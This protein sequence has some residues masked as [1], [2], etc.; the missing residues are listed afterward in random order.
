MRVFI[1]GIAGFIGSSL[2]DR[3]LLEGYEVWGCDTFGHYHPDY[4][5]KLKWRNVYANL[6]NPKYKLIEGDFSEEEVTNILATTEFDYVIHL[7]AHAGVRPSLEDPEK[8]Y[9]NNLIKSL[10]LLRALEKS[11]YRWKIKLIFA[12]SSSVYG[13]VKEFPWEESMNVSK[14]L[15]PYAGSK[16]ALEEVCYT[17]HNLTEIPMIGLR[18]FT[19]YGPRQR[20]DMAI[21]KF[22]KAIDEGTPIQLYGEQGETFRDYTYISDI[23]EG[24]F[25]CMSDVN[26]FEI[27]NI[28]RGEPVELHEMVAEIG[29]HMGKVPNCQLLQ[30]QPGEP[31]KTQASISKIKE[32][33]NYAPEVPYDEGIK[34]YVNW[35]KKSEN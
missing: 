32:R 2:A 1:T 34:R 16:K 19:V 29:V 11:P 27:F 28:G 8:Y 9:Q 5:S 23:I 15:S 33:H 18:F 21:A 22:T 30:V 6:S 4:P 13:G 7:A 10:S 35:Y 12:S 26:G 20:P 14:P 24:I 31:Q 3:L 25:C 17:Y